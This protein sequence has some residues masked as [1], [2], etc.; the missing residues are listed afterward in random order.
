MLIS[1]S[2]Y[3]HILNQQSLLN[4]YLPAYKLILFI[5]P[6]MFIFLILPIINVNNSKI[7]YNC[8]FFLL[9]T[10]F[11]NLHLEIFK[12]SYNFNISKREL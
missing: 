2:F 10:L 12:Y 1:L 4:N 11:K 8:L 5:N 6:H 9:F 7:I 3:L